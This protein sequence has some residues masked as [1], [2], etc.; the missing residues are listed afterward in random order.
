MNK[1]GVATGI[2]EL[3]TCSLE[4]MIIEIFPYILA[5]FL[6]I[7][8]TFVRQIIAQQNELKL[9]CPSHLT[10][11]TYFTACNVCRLMITSLHVIVSIYRHT[12][13][14]GSRRGT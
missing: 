12:V 5:K 7:L 3:D 2:G 4:K 11:C 9:I 8:T 1:L 6:P 10:L 13:N 14:G